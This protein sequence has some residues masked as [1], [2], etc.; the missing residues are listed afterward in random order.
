MSLERSAPHSW[1]RPAH[2][3]DGAGY[4]RS[5]VVE[6]IIKRKRLYNYYYSCY[7]Y[8]YTSLSRRLIVLQAS[9]KLFALT[10]R[11]SIQLH[12]NLSLSRQRALLRRRR[13]R[14][15]LFPFFLIPFP[16]RPMPQ[17]EYMLI[18][19]LV[20]IDPLVPQRWQHLTFW[21]EKRERDWV[22]RVCRAKPRSPIGYH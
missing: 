10:T 9:V 22:G 12:F 7:V 2:R 3:R 18:H 13:R 6:I 8:I 17:S 11:L 14:S 4:H 19:L 21:R 16:S 5:V 15:F 20:E 1:K